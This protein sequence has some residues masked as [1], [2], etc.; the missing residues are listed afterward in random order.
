MERLKHRPHVRVAARLA[1]AAWLLLALLPA[2]LAVR[3]P[4]GTMPGDGVPW[5]LLPPPAA[6]QSI[7]RLS[8]QI[9]DETGVLASGTSGIQSALDRLLS[10]RN[11]QLWVVFVH[12][13]GSQTAQ[14]MAEATFRQNG[15]GG[16]D[17]VLLVALDDKRYGYFVSD[18]LPLSSSQVD[19]AAS[20]DLEPGLRSGDYPGAVAAFANGLD[21]ALSGGAQNP[22]PVATPVPAQPAG[23]STPPAPS[24][25][26]D[27]GQVI[28]LIAIVAVVIGVVLLVVSISRWRTAH[29]AAEERDRR[30]GE[31]A[32][33]ANQLLIQADDAVRDAQQEVGF[34]EAEFSAADV[35]P[36]RAAVTQAQ[37]E[38]KAAFA[39]RQKLDDDIPEDPPTRIAML[40]EIVA[41]AQRVNALV[42]EQRTRIGQLR[43]LERRAP[44]ILAG[45]P[46]QAAPLQARLAEAPATMQRLQAFADRAWSPVKGNVEEAGKRFAFASSE[47]ARGNAALAATPPDPHAARDAARNAQGALAAA[48]TLLDAIDRMA[49]TIDDAQARLPGELSAAEADIATA[50]RTLG[51]KGAPS[52]DL[53]D[54]E[55]KLRAAKA[56]AEAPRPDVIAALKA[57]RDAHAGADRVLE[58]VRAEEERRARE[59][60]ALQAALGAAQSSVTHTSDYLDSRR[61]GVGREA[62]TRLAEAQRHLEMAQSL[63][64]SDPTT[65]LSEAQTAQRM[66]DEAYQLAKNDFDD[67]DMGGGWGG[68]RRG[69]DMTGAIIGG[70]ILGNVLGGMGRRGG[71]GFGGTPWGSGGFG[72]FGGGG[73]GGFGG[74]GG[75]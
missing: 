21:S 74:G 71:G 35:D 4:L 66:A 56:A 42:E 50:H 34:A 46:A 24:K 44:E 49:T 53:A 5:A 14:Q 62:R 57:A 31:L 48:G 73:G 45:L 13:S 69:S 36:Y 39:V 37:D 16:N 23:P 58:G 29:I 12:T 28:L 9:T 15:F 65:A 19:A 33:Q 7:P 70:I 32:R 60:A 11:V 6:A 41:H 43:D 52:G 75:W 61:Q 64:G 55:A 1:V 26:I 40:N 10:D 63:V 51:D 54:A 68:R 22:P 72:G 47:T 30:T 38:L 17:V 27:L 59:R 3:G 67:W 18:T 8:S 2:S 25:G 20:N